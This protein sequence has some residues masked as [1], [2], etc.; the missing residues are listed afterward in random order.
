MFISKFEVLFWSVKFDK[1]LVIVNNFPEGKRGCLKSV[2]VSVRPT[3]HIV[4]KVKAV[5]V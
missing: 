2:P 4:K 3:V 1:F 5:F